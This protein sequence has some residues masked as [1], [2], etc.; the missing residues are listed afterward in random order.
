[1]PWI[2]PPSSRTLL[3]FG[4]QVLYSVGSAACLLLVMLLRNCRPVDPLIRSTT[5]DHALACNLPGPRGGEAHFFTRPTAA[6]SQQRM[7]HTDARESIPNIVVGFPL[8]HVSSSQP[9]ERF[10]HNPVEW[11]SVEVSIHTT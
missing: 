4:R 7:G 10:L 3:G 1:M 11:I 2:S 9:H 5:I 8:T 6:E